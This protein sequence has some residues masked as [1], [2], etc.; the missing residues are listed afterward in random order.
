V[1][2]FRRGAKPPLTGFSQ[3]ERRL[4]PTP[5]KNVGDPRHGV[6]HGPRRPRDIN[7]SGR[8]LDG[9]AASSRARRI[10]AVT[11]ASTS[12]GR[13]LLLLN[14]HRKCLIS[15]D[16]VL[17]MVSYAI[18]ARLIALSTQTLFSGALY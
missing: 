4:K 6:D 14:R 5:H 7:S 8:R 1:A 11:Q 16:I 2:G 17:K 9:T 10:R 15:F 12:M 3:L 18:T 13:D